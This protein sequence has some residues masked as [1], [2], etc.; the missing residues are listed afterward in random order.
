MKLGKIGRIA[1]L[2]FA[3]LALAMAAPASA[4]TLE[5]G[6]AIDGSGSI[7]VA[8]FNLQ[9]NAYANVLSDLT[10]LP[11]NGTVAI[12]VKLFSNT[13]QTVF[14]MAEI[15]N[16]NHGAL[17]AAINGMVRPGST[18]NI[19]GAI[20]DFTAEIF[21]NAIASNRQLI[22]VSTDGFNNVGNL[23]AARAAAL[24]AG[25]D[26]INCIGVGA[27]TDC[28]NVIGG[29]GSF[30]LNANN[31]NDFEASLRRK[32]KIE[33]NGIPEPATWAMMIAGFGFVGAAA[34]RRQ[35]KMTVSYG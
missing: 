22:D 13:V 2:P 33:V 28:A 7:S 11:R 34:R 10:V 15:T 31:F 23:G 29:A 21:G 12:G 3:G 1:A 25:I 14:A 18:T 19:S 20:N 4:A 9:K 30:A 16:A 8:D 27:N 26:Q 32:I 17:I 35:R 24:A 6:L 5:L